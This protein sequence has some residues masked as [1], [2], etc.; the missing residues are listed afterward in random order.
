MKRILFPVLGAAIGGLFCHI[1][2]WLISKLA[3]TFDIRLYNSEEEASRNFTVFLV[4]FALFVVSG[5]VYGF[6]RAKKHS[7][8]MKHQAF[9]AYFNLEA[10]ITALPWSGNVDLDF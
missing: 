8:K 2:F 7:S 4:C 6:Y 9:Y 1:T 10:Y 3:V 5:F